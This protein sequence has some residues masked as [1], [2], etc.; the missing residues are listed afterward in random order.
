M[1]AEI[2]RTPTLDGTQWPTDAVFVID[3]VVRELVDADLGDHVIEVDAG[4]GLKTLEAVGELA[5]R[6]LSIRATRPLTIV[7]V[8]GGSVGDAV[9]FLASVLWRGVALWHVPTTWLAAVDSA[10]GGKTAVNLGAR[11][12]QLGT[13][14]EA[15]R[16]VL[17]DQILAALGPDHRAEGL[18]EMVKGMWLGDGEGLDL[19]DAV[20][21]E[22]L[23]ARP[24]DEVGDDLMELLDRSIA[25][26][27]SVVDRDPHETKGIRTVLNLGHTSAHAF[28]LHD[29]FPHGVAVAW[30][31]AA[32]AVVSADRGRVPASTRDRMVGHVHPLLGH[33]APTV[34]RTSF[35]HALEG[36]KKRR[37]GKLRSVL[38]AGPAAPVVVDD[39]T[40]N[41]W[42]GALD[43]VKTLHASPI[44]VRFDRPTGARLQVEASKSELNRILAIEALRPG[45]T[46]PQ[47]DS[48]ADDVGRFRAALRALEEGE[49]ADVGEGGTTFRFLLA[50]AASRWERR[51]L[52]VGESLAARPHEPLLDA[53]RNAGATAED[54]GDGTYEVGGL[55]RGSVDFVVQSTMSSQ[56]ASALALLAASG[57]RVNLRV[58]QSLPSRGYFDMTLALLERAGVQIVRDGRNHR[59]TPTDRLASAV[60]LRAA[61]DAS[62]LAVWQVARRLGAT[63]EL[64]DDAESLQPDSR[65]AALLWDADRNAEIELDLGDTPDLVPVFTAYAALTQPAVRLVGAEHLRHKESNRIDDLVDAM[66]RVGITVRPLSDGV[67]VPEG[68]QTPRAGARFPTHRDHRL[69]MAGALLSHAAELV[70]EAP[71]VVN[72]SYPTFW[73]DLVA[74]GWRLEPS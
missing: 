19:L 36:D 63:V 44:R 68:V 72:K 40:P 6:V 4:E 73:R 42:Y 64:N 34:D 45:P 56:Y 7:A 57:R 30:G 65:A 32:A 31:L 10:H 33:H 23:V 67:E 70:I 71:R 47:G 8:G 39:V 27:R 38:L 5:E 62:S 16:V 61:P 1:E 25:V 15:E 60:T 18:A 17:C 58:S 49:E 52:H 74:A 59:L 53:L 54:L 37:G 51:R 48:Q 46:R 13:F 50:V 66:T 29:R 26:K 20:G 41:E 55:P 11:K 14:W 12:N 24:W 3:R 35:V 43:R 69:A 9:G 22:R 21:V 2:V 28:E